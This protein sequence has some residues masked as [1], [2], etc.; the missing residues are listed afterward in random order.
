MHATKIEMKSTWPT[1]S[2]FQS[3]R[4]YRIPACRSNFVHWC[5]DV[6]VVKRP[7]FSYGQRSELQVGWQHNPKQFSR[8]ISF[9]TSTFFTYTATHTQKFLATMY[10]LDIWVKLHN[11]LACHVTFG[12]KAI[13]PKH[14][15]EEDHK[16][17]LPQLELPSLYKKI[18]WLFKN[19][20]EIYTKIR[21][22]RIMVND[23]WL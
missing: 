16:T 20:N 13:K 14:L 21:V 23:S 11:F 2:G 15:Y 12:V 17:S 19:Q 22:D 1:L 5:D 6:V 18:N 10:I 7:Q 9:S 4:Q 3:C 8:K